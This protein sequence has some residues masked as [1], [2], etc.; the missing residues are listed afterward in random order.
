MSSPPVST[1]TA[2]ACAGVAGVF[3]L[4]LS[5]LLCL[6][7]EA[8]VASDPLD[9]RA[10]KIMKSVYHGTVKDDAM[11]RALAALR[12]RLE[13]IDPGADL[14]QSAALL[15]ALTRP[16]ATRPEDKL[17]RAA[18]R[19]LDLLYRARFFRYR[20]RANSGR[21]LL[22]GGA[23][24]LLLSLHAAVRGRQRPL[25]PRRRPVPDR[26]RFARTGYV[27]IAAVSVLALLG[28]FGAYSLRPEPV[29]P[30]ARATFLENYRPPSAEAW[31]AN[32]PVFRGPGGAGIAPPGN[33][34]KTWNGATGENVAWKAPV[35]LRGNGSPVIFG[36]ALFLTGA[37]REERAL[38]CFD[39]GDGTLRWSRTVSAPAGSPPGPA[40]MFADTGYAAPTP[41]TDGR[42][43][44]AIFANGD[45]ACYTVD[46][47]RLWVRNL[48]VPE[49]IYG[50]AAS[51][52]LDRGALFVLYDQGAA[53]EDGMSALLAIDAPTGKTLWRAKRPVANS[54][55]SP[56]LARTPTRTAL[57]ASACPWVVAYDPQTGEE[58]WRAR[59]AYGYVDTGPSPVADGERVYVTTAGAETTAIDLGGTGD[60]TETHIRWRNMLGQPDTASPLVAGELLVLAES[61]GSV[62]AQRTEDGEEVWQHWFDHGFSASPSRVGEEIWLLDIAGRLHRLACAQTLEVLGVN[63]LG[64]KTVASPAF[65]ADR[66]YMRGEKHIFCLGSAP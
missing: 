20:Y 26:E 8:M 13:A 16:P 45:L 1:R 44:A 64:E 51:L 3:C 37:T 5:V 17:L 32:W 48:G 46:G 31:R 41:A 15:D 18:Y 52:A 4:V 36:D 33:Y 62:L 7:A 59:V 2:L 40:E 6:N 30:S 38:Y 55:T 58:Y 14:P 11:P 21:W 57:I 9:A 65:H 25:D 50:Y 47:L 28:A 42:I 49:S 29:G 61:T 22:L 10:L 35:P 12:D 56:I 53:A 60:V 54:W 63:D 43:V 34:P 23:L 39:A 24:A 19:E 66:V 27:A